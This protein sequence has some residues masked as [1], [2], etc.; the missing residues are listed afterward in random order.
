MISLVFFDDLSKE[1]ETNDVFL[2]HA[3]S[4]KVPKDTIVICTV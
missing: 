4:N 2:Q 3:D 1:K